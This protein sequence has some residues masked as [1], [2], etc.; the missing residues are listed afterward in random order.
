MAS[1]ID[2][3]F[4]LELMAPAAR[5][6]A[7]AGHLDRGL[8]GLQLLGAD[9]FEPPRDVLE[10]RVRLG[11]FSLEGLH[12]LRE[13]LVLVS[14]LLHLDLGDV[15]LLLQIALLLPLEA[16]EYDQDSERRRDQHRLEWFR[17]FRFLCHFVHSEPPSARCRT[18]RRVS[19]HAIGVPSRNQD[20]ERSATG[21]LVIERTLRLESIPEIVYRAVPIGADPNPTLVAIQS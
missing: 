13:L 16:A 14:E 11:G 3:M 6:V 12:R 21:G 17:S 8:D 15:S 4:R 2:W 19:V 10:R 7:F 5:S 20:Q 9:L 1:R 18:L